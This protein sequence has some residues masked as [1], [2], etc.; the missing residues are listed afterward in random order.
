M[1][2]R[3]RPYLRIRDVYGHR[4][5]GVARATTRRRVADPGGDT[6]S[7][8]RD[9]LGIATIESSS[10]IRESRR[11]N[12]SR[13]RRDIVAVPDDPRAA[14]LRVRARARTR[15]SFPLSPARLFARCHRAPPYPLAVK[16]ASK[17]TKNGAAR[18]HCRARS[19]DAGRRD[20]HP[21]P[22]ARDGRDATI[23]HRRRAIPLYLSG[24]LLE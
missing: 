15:C 4:Q 1:C 2:M 13:A 3:V 18:Y 9:P 10:T 23:S 16:S 8:H 21:R 17:R 12:S 22:D 24:K 5:R 19:S 11:I 6:R 7:R 20:A 14:V